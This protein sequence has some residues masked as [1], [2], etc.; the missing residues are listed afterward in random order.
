MSHNSGKST[1]AAAYFAATVLDIPIVLSTGEEIRTRHPDQI[2]KCLKFFCIGVNSRHIGETIHRL[3]FRAGLFKVAY[4]PKTKSLRSYDEDNDKAAGIKPKMSPPLIPARF[5]ESFSWDNKADNVFT[6]CIV[7]NQQGVVCAE[8]LA[9]TSSGKPPQGQPVS[10]I[11]W[12]DEQLPVD[13][14][15]AEMRSRLVDY[16]E[17]GAKLIWSSWPD[18]SS[19]ELEEFREMI[20]RELEAQ[21]G[22]AAK[23]T[24]AM[25]KNRALGK[26]AIASFL[27]GC[28]TQEERDARDKGLFVTERLRMYPHFDKHIHTAIINEAEYED[29]VSRILRKTDGIPPDTW[30]KT[31]ALDPGTRAPGVLLCAVP[32]PELGDYAI[33]YQEIYPGRADPWQLARKVH[34]AIMGQKIYQFIIDRHAGRQQTMGMAAHSRVVDSYINAFEMMKLKCVVS[35]SQFLFGCDDVGG[36]QLVL[37]GWMHPQQGQKL[38]KLRIVTHRC[39]NLCEQLEKVKKRVVA[40]QEMDERKARGDWDIIDCYDSQTEVLTSTGWKLFSE[41]TMDDKLAAMSMESRLI[42][43]QSPSRIVAK[44]YSGEMV[45]VKSRRMD[46]LVTPNH[47][48]VVHDA[49]GRLRIRLAKDLLKSDRVLLAADGVATSSDPKLIIPRQYNATGQVDEIED[50]EAFAEF[51]GLYLAEGCCVKYMKIGRGYQVLISQ[52]KPHGRKYIEQLLERLPF[53]FTADAS[54]YRT[55]HKQLWHYL[56]PLGNVY[57]KHVPEWVFSCKQSTLEAFVRGYIAGDG[58]VSGT[59]F[60]CG[61]VSRELTDGIQAAAALA[62]YATS[63]YIRQNAGKTS[64]IRGRCVTATKDLACMTIGKNSKLASLKRHSGLPSAEAK[65]WIEK[66]EGLVYCATV[67]NSTLVV[68]RNN[69]T[70]ICGNCAEYIAASGPRYIPVKQSISDGSPAYQRYMKKFGNKTTRPSITFGV[71]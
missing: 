7:K 40:K 52:K 50:V 8:I 31:L 3:L 60:G 25:S 45:R 44:P 1:C 34:E 51:I 10:G 19:S 22:V 15:A 59:S 68:R 5:I 53:H 54:G 16:A 9:Y 17:S 13:G 43:F 14:Y 58:W 67:E 65:F 11:I 2:G 29:E 46:L 12:I 30:T 47:R 48:M 57:S 33:M 69:K 37:Q 39:P 71:Y 20:D 24:L 26:T 66:Y 62:G 61:S 35:G 21:S 18:E 56:R 55:S 41:I 49:S 42:E 4:D 38:P 27:A 23:F 32:P 70:A 6:K 63:Q 28:A 64:E 36:R